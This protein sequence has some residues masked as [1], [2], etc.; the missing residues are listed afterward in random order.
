MVVNDDHLCLPKSKA[1]IELS[2]LTGTVTAT[3]KVLVHL[4]NTMASHSIAKSQHKRKQ[5]NLTQ[6]QA[7]L[8]V[9]KAYINTRLTVSE[10]KASIIVHHVDTLI[11]LPSQRWMPPGTGRSKRRRSPWNLVPSSMKFTCSALA[12]KRTKR[13]KRKKK[14]RTNFFFTP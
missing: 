10:K 8:Q 9:G 1:S 4:W 14:R 11:R 2:S 13:K 5:R 3:G 12:Q 7:N 6:S